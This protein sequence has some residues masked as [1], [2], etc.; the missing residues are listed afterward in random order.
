MG[1]AEVRETELPDLCQAAGELTPFSE[2]VT[3]VEWASLMHDVIADRGT[4]KLDTY[5][6]R[7]SAAQA[8]DLDEQA[9]ALSWMRHEHRQRLEKVDKRQ[10]LLFEHDIVERMRSDKTFGA[11][12]LA[13]AELSAIT[14]GSLF[15]AAFGGGGDSGGARGG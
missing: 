8:V 1:E 15:D 10:E 4:E 13:A 3:N 12:D 14:P 7:L 9:E 5:F 2:G 11:S 6:V